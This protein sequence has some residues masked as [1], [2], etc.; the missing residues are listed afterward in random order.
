MHRVGITF[1]VAF[2]PFV[3]CAGQI[4]KTKIN[5]VVVS[6]SVSPRTQRH[7]QRRRTKDSARRH[8]CAAA[9]PGA[10]KYAMLFVH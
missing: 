2:S 4:V 1:S 6:V 10:D 3:V 8:L 7:W 5:L 9:S